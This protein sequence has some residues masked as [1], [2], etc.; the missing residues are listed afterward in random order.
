VIDIIKFTKQKQIALEDLEELR[1]MK[2]KRI[3]E[4]I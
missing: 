2:I 4:V 3:N 1:D